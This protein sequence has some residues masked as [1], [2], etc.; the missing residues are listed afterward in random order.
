MDELS[1]VIISLIGSAVISVLVAKYYGERWVET[2]RSRMEH[3]VKLKDDF[4]KSWLS[5]IG[6]YSDE[7]HKI[8]CKIGTQYSK[9]IG[10]MVPLEPEEP[11]NLQFYDEAVSHMKNYEQLIKDWKNLKQITLKLNEEL[12]ILFEEIRILVKKEID[13]PYWCPGYSGDEPDKY[14]CPNTFIGSIYE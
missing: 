10:K 6:G 11:D 9:E 8:Y 7:Y 4:F 1:T 14:L 5:K 13:F 3:S 2:R 12:A